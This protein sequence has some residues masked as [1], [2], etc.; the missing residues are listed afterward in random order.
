VRIGRYLADQ[1]GVDATPDAMATV[2]S[3]R[4]LMAAAELKADLFAHPD[5][6]RWSDEVVASML[7][8]QPVIDGDLIPER[9]VDRIAAG[10]AAGVDVVVGTNAED[11][12]LFVIANGSLERVTDEILAGPVAEHGFETAAAY[13]VSGDRLAAYRAAYPG[14]SPGELLAAIETDWWCRGPALRLAE[15]HATDRAGTYMYEFAWRAAGFGACH[16][17]EI[18]FVF[19]TLERGPEQMMGLML[20]G[21]PPQALATDMHGAWVA[22]ATTGDPGWPRYERGPRATMIFDTVSRVVDD[23]RSWERSLWLRPG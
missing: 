17:L 8:W 13:G 9:P 5:P 6:A 15:A 12:R 7:P 20:G 19:D 18:P 10:A 11:W 14:A 23:P 21:D 4:L 3:D 2:P 16:A 22:F 1:L